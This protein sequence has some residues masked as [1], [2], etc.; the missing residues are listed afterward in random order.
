MFNQSITWSDTCSWC[1]ESGECAENI[2]DYYG[3]RIENQNKACFI[4]DTDCLP[5]N[6][7]PEKDPPTLENAITNSLCELHV[8]HLFPICLCSNMKLLFFLSM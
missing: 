5:S 3:N 7:L 2:Y 1:E 8:R 4:R 6:S